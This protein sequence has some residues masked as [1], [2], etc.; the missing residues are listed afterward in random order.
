MI[1]TL[2]RSWILNTATLF[3]LLYPWKIVPANTN[4]TTRQYLQLVFPH[5]V[6]DILLNINILQL[7]LFNERTGTTCDANQGATIFRTIVIGQI[8]LSVCIH[9]WYLSHFHYLYLSSPELIYI[10]DLS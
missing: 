2:Y 8:S 7:A 10:H 5:V 4:K 6:P 1:G 9:L 3:L